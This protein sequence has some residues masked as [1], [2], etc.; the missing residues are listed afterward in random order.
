MQE[1]LQYG[2]VFCPK[3]SFIMG[4]FSDPQH[5]HPGISYWSRPPGGC[6]APCNA[7]NRHIMLVHSYC[8]LGCVINDE[9]SITNDFKAVYGK[10]DH[11]VYVLGKL[12]YFV[13][14]ETVPTIRLSCLILITVVFFY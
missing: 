1:S 11:K 8:Y 9:W 2:Y 4:P 14:K 13:D 7:G 6:P 5:T 12:R 10:A 3:R